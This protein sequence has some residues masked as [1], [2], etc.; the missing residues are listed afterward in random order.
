MGFALSNVGDGNLTQTRCRNDEYVFL[1]NTVRA[2]PT[3]T[4]QGSLDATPATAPA[5]AQSIPGAADGFQDTVS[6][7]G[8][9]D[10]QA[11]TIVDV[12]PRPGD[13]DVI[14][15]GL[16]NP[17]NAPPVTLT[18][19][20]VAPPGSD[21]S[22]SVAPDPCRIEVGY[23]PPGCQAANW[24]SPPTDLSTVTAV[25]RFSARTARLDKVSWRMWSAPGS[26]RPSLRRTRDCVSCTHARDSS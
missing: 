12:L 18:G 16:R 4:A 14:D 8:T 5:I 21:I 15:P 23:S 10:L 24:S 26:P 13:R 25:K 2:T 19:P 20:I 22:Y 7:D 17:A 3:A 9:T 6:N 1:S 11:V